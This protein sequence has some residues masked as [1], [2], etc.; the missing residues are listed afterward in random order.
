MMTG[1]MKASLTTLL[2]LG[3][4][5]PGPL[6]NWFYNTIVVNHFKWSA[7]LFA[8]RINL[9]IVIATFAFTMLGFLAAII[10]ILFS[11]TNTRTLRKYRKHN[12]LEI[13]FRFYYFS[14][15][16]LIFTF[17][18]ALLGFGKE[19]SPG[20]FQ[21]MITSAINNLTQISLIALVIINIARKAS[22]E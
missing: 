10:T 17:I 2:I 19:G 3:S 6:L 13:F 4:L 16:C 11:L 7:G 12:H 21:L 20:M 15:V 5:L 22:E 14:I 18:L 1:L 9:S 8:Q